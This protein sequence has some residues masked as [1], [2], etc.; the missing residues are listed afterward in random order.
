[1]N[2]RL[3]SPNATYWSAAVK[4][5]VPG[6]GWSDSHFSAFS[7]VIALN[8]AVTRAAP[9][10]SRPENC[11]ALSAAP[12]RKAPAKAALRVRGGRAHPVA[13]TPASITPL[14]AG[15]SVLMR[16]PS[17]PR[18]LRER[19]GAAGGQVDLGLR[20]RPEVVLR[21]VEEPAV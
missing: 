6:R 3:R 15:R 13:S 17:V 14:Q 21:L 19:P 5:Y 7:G 4:S 18:V 12:T 2:I 20:D 10:V 11:S 16:A 8:C 9:S 1:M